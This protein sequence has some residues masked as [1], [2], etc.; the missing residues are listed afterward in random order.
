MDLS[1]KEMFNQNESKAEMG[2]WEGG[3]LVLD[4]TDKEFH[5]KKSILIDKL[6]IGGKEMKLM[7][8]RNSG[9]YMLGYDETLII[10]TKNG[11]EEVEKFANVLYIDF[12]KQASLGHNLGNNKLYRVKEVAVS[13]KKDMQSKGI[14]TAV[15][16]YF[17]QKKGWDLLSDSHQYYGAKRLWSRLSKELDV[18]VDLV[19][20]K[21]REIFDTNV[22]LHHGK[23]DEDF[24]KR[25]WSLGEDK[26]HIR[27]I[28]KAII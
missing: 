6:D 10:D 26:L 21:K 22:T 28:L 2:D 17:V 7:Q 12:E 4:Y 11:E 25:V 16:K 8:Y 5:Y 3:E 24:D 14:A 1:F 15:Y 20:V 9:K 27:C 19:D 23:Y 18:R 13:N